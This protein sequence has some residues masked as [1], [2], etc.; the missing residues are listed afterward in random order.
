[1]H[2]LA[3][4]GIAK[5]TI[6]TDELATVNPD[7]EKFKEL[8]NF[9]YFTAY[10]S[11]LVGLFEPDDNLKIISTALRLVQRVNLP[12]SAASLLINLS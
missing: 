4:S 11:Y 2:P 9:Y 5:I 12:R 8:R 6:C 1:M 10:S 7:F 3:Q